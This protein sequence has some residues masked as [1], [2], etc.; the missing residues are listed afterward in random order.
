MEFAEVIRQR[1]SVRKYADRPIEDEK[2]RYVLEAARSAP[3][4]SNRQSARH[5]VVRDPATIA[6][7]GKPSGAINRWL[8]KAPTVIVVC[9]D[10]SRPYSDHGVHFWQVD[11]TIAAEHI[12]LAAVDVGLGTC[13]IGVFDEAE[14][15]ATLGIPDEVLILGL[16]AIGYP[17]ERMSAEERLTR[18]AIRADKRRPLDESVHWERW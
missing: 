17:A 8:A 18:T 1:R 3:S 14:I 4:A 10:A 7:I 9:G 15:R 2:L 12:V 11:A 13:W 16:L 5:I 6:A